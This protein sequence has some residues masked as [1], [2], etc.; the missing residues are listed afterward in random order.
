MAFCFHCIFH[1]NLTSIL[2]IL[3]LEFYSLLHEINSPLKKH[4]PGVL[5]SGIVYL[6]D[7]SFSTSTWDGKGVP[8][9]IAKSNLIR[10]KCDDGFSFG[11]WGKKQLEYR[12]AGMPV[13]GSV[14]LAGH[15]NIWP[16]MITKRCEGKIFAEL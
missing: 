7:G 3:Q 4:I 14:N 9:V 5:A 16:Y 15:S 2:Y 12:Y 11:V 6:E 13:D 8:G 1:T 10:T